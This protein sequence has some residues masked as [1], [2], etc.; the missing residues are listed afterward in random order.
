EPALGLFEGH[1]D[2]G[3]VLHPGS[4]EYDASH[5]TYQISGSGDNMWAATDA[6]HFVCKKVSGDVTL[7]ADVSI[8]G[9]GGDGHR[10]A[11]LMI[12]QSLDTDSAYVDAARHGDGLTSIQS[13]LEKGGNSSEVQSNVSKPTRL[14]IAK[15]GDSF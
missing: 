3:T 4:V 15:R 1:S 2:V 13:R 8:L 5:R 11:V 9:A 6:F 10:K 14:R 12:R 7:T